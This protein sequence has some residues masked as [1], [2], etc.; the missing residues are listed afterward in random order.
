MVLR[1]NIEIPYG[2]TTKLAPIKIIAPA[3]KSICGNFRALSLILSGVEV[4]T[5][6]FI[7]G[8]LIR[9]FWRAH[10]QPASQPASQLSLTHI[11][12]LSFLVFIIST[13]FRI[14]THQF[15][16]YAYSMLF[17]LIINSN[18]CH[19]SIFLFIR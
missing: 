3:D 1:M 19:Q 5:C 14:Q 13:N 11:L 2:R 7:A 6:R 17:R 8:I 18:V 16:E 4:D 10:I 9:L 15:Y 12:S